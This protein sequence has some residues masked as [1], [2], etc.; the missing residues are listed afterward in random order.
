VES[1]RHALAEL[2]ADLNLQN[3]LGNSQTVVRILINRGEVYLKLNELDSAL[4]DARQAVALARKLKPETLLIDALNFAARVHRVRQDNT[5]ASPL[6]IEARALSRRLKYRFGEAASLMESSAVGLQE[7]QLA[8][9][10]S[11]AHEAL[12]IW[13]ELGD[14]RGEART[15]FC[16]GEASMRLGLLKQSEDSLQA[17]GG[18][19][20]ELRDPTQLADTLIDLN[21]LAQREGQWQKDLSIL[22]EASALVHDR[23]AEPYMCA[24]IAG[25]FGEVYEAYGRLDSA[26]SSYQDAL[27]LYRDF[28]H[29]KVAT[30][31]FLGKVGRIQVRMGDYA[32]AEANIQKC[33]QMVRVAEGRFT[34]ALCHEELGRLYLATRSYPQSLKQF[35]AAS[36]EYRTMKS[37]RE[38][39]RAQTFLGQIEYLQGNLKQAEAFY[40]D[41]LKVFAEVRDYSNEAALCFGLGKLELDQH[42]LDDAGKHL[43]RSLALTEQLR[44]NAASKDLRSSF[45]ASAHDRFEVYV[46]WLMERHAREP[47]RQFNVAAFETSESGRARS[48]LDS[49]KDY[50]RE[51][52]QVS[53]PNLLSEEEKIQKEEQQLLDKRASLKSED[54]SPEE[55][56][57][58]ENQLTDVRSR[59]EALEA[60]I[61]TSNR[62]NDLMHPSPLT[63]GEIQTR[64]LDPET[65]LL[66]YSLGDRKSYLWLVTTEGIGSYEL[67]PKETIEKASRRL[68]QLLAGPS[69]NTES[70]L[71]ASIAEVS[72]IVIGPVADKLRSKRLIIVADG[73]LQY[74]PFQILKSPSYPNEPLVAMHEIVNAPSASTL[75]KL[76]EEAV[77]R[78]VAP[79]LIAA[80]GDPVLPLNYDLKASGSGTGKVRPAAR[81]SEDGLDDR[82]EPNKLQG[83][84]YSTRELNELR[85]VTS[86]DRSIIYSDFAATRDN[87]KSLDLSQYRILHFATHGVLDAK[88]PELSGLVLSLV[89]RQGKPINGFVGLSDIYNLRA[90]VDLVILSA[91]RTALGKDERGEGPLSLTRG[92]MYAGASSVV[93]S[94]WKVDDEAT[95]ELM[96]RFYENMLQRG[97][98]PAAALRGAQ[99]SIRQEPQWSSPYYWAA[100]TLQGDYRQVIKPTSANAESTRLLIIIGVVLAILS[101][102]LYRSHSR[103]RAG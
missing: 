100:F 42:R 80:L 103:M 60:R 95:S 99:N 77:H 62:F 71:E 22:A 75:A 102:W 54:A 88:Q 47:Q 12:K 57:K 5:K 84:F 27:I 15:L 7:A 97:M 16:L 70:Q 74:I 83:L 35:L 90:P 67:P 11:S 39:A 81:G 24:Q 23:D 98:T 29:D 18:I 89:D 87:L 6:L 73:I 31:Y 94:L 40:L 92:F 55:K 34:V 59:H 36:A 76:H 14:K 10:E 21:F 1:R 13:R 91:C 4:Q 72:K 64:L 33:L 63:C 8:Q 38:W 28:A 82:F 61:N 56:A 85:K 66:E 65:S 19:W 25:S 45:L 53:D 58:L 78:S 101:A 49:L 93:A 79:N 2:N 69:D 20:R 96:K 48:L 86:A 41:A 68:A 46:E 50:Q 37:R 3:R 43:E 30:A 17:A 51:L 26:L 44:E 32:T 52:R 9:A